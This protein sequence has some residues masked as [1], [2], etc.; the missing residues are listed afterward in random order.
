[1]PPS[2]YL[3]RLSTK[4]LVHTIGTCEAYGKVFA[5]SYILLFSWAKYPSRHNQAKAFLISTCNVVILVSDS[6]RDASTITNNVKLKL[7]RLPLI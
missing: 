3:Y 5:C 7:Y 2:K 1:M 6:H 4:L